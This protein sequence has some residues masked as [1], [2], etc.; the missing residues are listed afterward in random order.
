MKLEKT[1]Y[2]KIEKGTGGGAD[3]FVAE[4]EL[5]YLVGMGEKITV[6]VY[7]L[8]ETKTVQGVAQVGKARAAR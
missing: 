8:I 6:G 7:R 1:L 5:D 3:Y 4:A 2:V